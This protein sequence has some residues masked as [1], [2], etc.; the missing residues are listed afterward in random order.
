MQR[1]GS[2]LHVL[3][4]AFLAFVAGSMVVLANVFPAQPLRDG[5]FAVQRRAND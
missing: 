2:S 5:R 3:A 4:I 1:L